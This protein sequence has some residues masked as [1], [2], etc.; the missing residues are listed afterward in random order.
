ML[1]VIGNWSPTRHPRVA[2][3]PT[4]LPRPWHCHSHPRRRYQGACGDCPPGRPHL[5]QHDQ[6]GWSLRRGESGHIDEDG[7]KLIFFS[8]ISQAFAG[9]DTNRS[10]G[11]FGDQR[12]WGYIIIL[13]AV[14]TKDFMSAEVF[15]FDN[16]FLAVSHLLFILGALE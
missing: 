2:R 16:A 1:M 3:E 14:R 12:V 9:L 10:V 13:R 4:P 5:H 8:Q 15:N 7:R 11:V 6:G